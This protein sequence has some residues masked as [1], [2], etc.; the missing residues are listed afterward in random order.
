[1]TTLKA[2]EIMA[3]SKS[4]AAKVAKS[5]RDELG[6][7]AYPVDTVVRITGTLSVLE[8]T[9]KTST[10]TLLNEDFLSLVLH[11]AGIT[12]ERAAEVIS[13]IA[14]EYM[15][16][17]T[18][19]K[20][21]KKAAKKA[22]QERVKAF[23]PEGKISKIF[24]DVKARVPRTPVRGSVKFAGACEAVESSVEVGSLAEETA[25]TA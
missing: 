8:D 2:Q 25:K 18:G 15:E 6:P 7:G 1:M 13:E 9:E 4:I 22:R 16:E 10:S 14:G 24:A 5:A 11:H 20:E 21:D 17:W 12:R 3:V 19:S 23:D